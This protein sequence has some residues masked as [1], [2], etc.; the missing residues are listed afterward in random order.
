M[1][2]E[3]GEQVKLIDFNVSKSFGDACGMSQMMTKTGNLLYRAPEL[4]DDGPFG[5]SANV[6]IWSVGATLFYMLT[7]RHAFESDK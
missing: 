4:L 1:V 6:D 2:T 7:G 5:Y 3:G